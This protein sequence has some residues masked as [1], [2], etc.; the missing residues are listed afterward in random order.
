MNTERCTVCGFDGSRWTDSAAVERIAELPAL[1]CQAISGIDLTDLLRRPIADMW[2]I[3]EYT[4][5]VRETI[6]GM[7]FVLNIALTDP[8]TD[9]GDAPEP[10]FDPQP[11]PIDVPQALTALGDEV[12][13]LV[14]QLTTTAAERWG[15]AVTV[16][17]DQIDVHWI[18]RHAVH[19]VSHHLGD[20]ERLH[21]ALR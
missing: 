1:W 21:S 16:G 7:R 8:A 2:S 20:V 10:R 5:H 12:R 3:A 18:A 4:D 17:S 15:S 13:Q 14:E 9:L 19:D 6:F 11:R